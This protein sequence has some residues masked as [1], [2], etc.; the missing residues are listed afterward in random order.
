[1]SVFGPRY[2]RAFVQVADASHLDP[3]QVKQQLADFAETL[4]GSAELREVFADPSIEM[5]Q[6]LKV[7]DGIAARL[8]TFAAVRNLLAVIIDHQRLHALPEIVA[9]VHVLVDEEAR[10]VEAEVM[11]AHPLHQEDRSELERQ[12][13]RLAGSQVRTSYTED[14]S[15][16]GGAVVRIGS[17]V[18][19]GSLRAQLQAMRHRLVNAQPA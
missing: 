10:I 13:S 19:D 16:L 9:E 3:V 14:A 15:L 7:L 18:Y 2:A 6:K 17:R 11:S 8:G 5:S 12:I 1:M 4:A